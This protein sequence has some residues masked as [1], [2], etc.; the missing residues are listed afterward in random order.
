MRI[1]SETNK[2]RVF[3]R[4]NSG[5]AVEVPSDAMAVVVKTAFARANV[6]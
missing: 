1:G 2:G 6:R 5:A 3:A 4:S